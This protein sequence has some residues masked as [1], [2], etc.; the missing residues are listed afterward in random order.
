M[1]TLIVYYSLSG[2][3]RLLVA[4]LCKRLQCDAF[5]LRPRKR[6]TKLDLLIDAFAYRTPP[7]DPLPFDLLDYDRVIMVAPIWNARIAAP[8]RAFARQHG[9]KLGNYAFVTACAGRPLQYV[10]LYNELTRF[11]GRGPKQLVQLEMQ[12]LLPPQERKG[13]NASAYRLKP[14]DLTTLAPQLDRFVASMGGPD[15]PGRRTNAPRPPVELPRYMH[16]F[17]LPELAPDRSS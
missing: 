9:G 7:N 17:E 12:A 13:R 11:V 4:E 15:A 3:N 1:K 5:E 8:I 14:E 2:N 6:R 16:S 10:R